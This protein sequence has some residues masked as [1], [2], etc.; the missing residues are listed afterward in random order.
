MIDWLISGLSK[1]TLCCQKGILDKETE[2]LLQQTNRM[3][4]KSFYANQNS[5]ILQHSQNRPIG[6]RWLKC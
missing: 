5:D 4:D 2:G 3:D 1:A 6:E